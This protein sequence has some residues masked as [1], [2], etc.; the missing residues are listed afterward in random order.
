MPR[1]KQKIEEDPPEETVTDPN[2][3]DFVSKLPIAIL[4]HIVSYVP[5]PRNLREIS[6][7]WR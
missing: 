7:T 4:R 6:K 3:Y 5:R 1:K 2:A